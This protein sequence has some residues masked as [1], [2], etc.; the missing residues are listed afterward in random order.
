MTWGKWYWPAWLLAALV[1]FAVPEGIALARG[2]T[3][4]SLRQVDN[5]LSGWIWVH[6]KVVKGEVITQWS[7]TDFLIFGAWVVLAVW[8]TA[9]FFFRK[10]V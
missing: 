2:V 6:L 1:T 4:N 8:L 10:F 9:H 7:A 3:P 5:T